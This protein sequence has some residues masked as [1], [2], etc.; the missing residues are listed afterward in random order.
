MPL[1][2]R[3]TVER[4][5]PLLGLLL[6]A[7]ALYLMYRELRGFRYQDVVSYLEALPVLTVLAALGLTAARFFVLNHLA[8]SLMPLRMRS[9]ESLSFASFLSFASLWI[10]SSAVLHMSSKAAT[11]SPAVPCGQPSVPQ[12]LLRAQDGGVP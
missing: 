1:P 12:I 3:K 10:V 4:F 11:A 2:Q 5:L 8:T 9:F 7:G 6:F